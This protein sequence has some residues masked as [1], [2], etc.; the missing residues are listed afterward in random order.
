[1]QILQVAK[2]T[3]KAQV[4]AANFLEAGWFLG[5]ER[6]KSQFPHQLQRQN[7]LLQ[8]AVVHRFFG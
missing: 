8:E 2:L 5:I 4:V 3:G 7:I 1:M 6:N